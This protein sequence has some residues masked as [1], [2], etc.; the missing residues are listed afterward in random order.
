M[1]DTDLYDADSKSTASKRMA[2]ESVIGFIA[3]IIIQS[4]FRIRKNKQYVNNNI[5]YYKFNVKPNKNQT[6]A[7][8][9]HDVVS[10]LVYDGECLVIKSRT[11]DLLIADDFNRRE[12]AVREDVFSNVYVKGLEMTGTFT[13]SEVLYFEYGNEELSRLVDSLFYDYGELISRMFETHK[14]KNQIRSTV[15]VPAQM[16]K[17]KEGQ[18]KLQ[19]FIDRAYKAFKEK[20]IAIVPQQDGM[21]YQEHSKPQGSAGQSVDEINKVTNG[22]LDKI[23]HAVGLP[24]SLL[25]GDM[26]DVEKLTRNGMKFCIDPILTII[27]DEL[28]MQFVDRSDYLKGERIEVKRIS[29]RDMFDVAAAIDKLRSSSVANGHE[30]RDEVGLEHSDN[31]IH[32]EFLMTKNYE[33]VEGGED[34]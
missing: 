33:S 31:P 19:A 5:T 30:L 20:A 24:P 10:K 6:A 15:D 26:A 16:M 34:E 22:F 27:K 2:I 9:W 18:G 13:R 32:D 14:T 8:F 28:N 11:D 21:Q 3:R 25:K 17:T 1:D 12:Y 7:K 4:E 23:C 29:Y